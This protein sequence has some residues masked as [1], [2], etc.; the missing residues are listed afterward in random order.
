M[1]DPTER[2]RDILEAINQIEKYSI[3]GRESFEENELIQSWFIR[4]LQIIGESA[5]SLPQDFCDSISEIPWS[6]IIGMRNILVH[7]YFRIDTELVWDVIEKDLPT[8]K[9]KIQSILR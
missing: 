2:L 8:L 4:H 7:D 9:I 1:R 5:R 3:Q 6:K